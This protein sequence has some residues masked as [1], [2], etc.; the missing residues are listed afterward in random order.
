MEFIEFGGEWYMNYISLAHAIAII[1]HFLTEYFNTRNKLVS[2]FFMVVKIFTYFFTHYAVQTGIVFEECR[3][4]IIDESQVMAWLSYEVIAFYLNIVAIAVFILFSSCKK[5]Y[6]LRDRMQLAG[7]RR[8]KEDFLNYI[9]EDIHWFCMW[10]TMLMLTILALVMRTRSHE[11]I[12]K[13]VGVLFTRHFLELI[14]MGSFYY[15]KDF[16]LGTFFKAVIGCILLINIF[17]I[18]VF[19]ELETEF[20]VWWAPVVLL[21]VTLHFYM[22]FQIGYMY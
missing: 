20:S 14:L 11:L 4:G 22:F 9:K 21:D 18:L 13:S 19:L 10:F 7:E 15:S 16:S 12:Q 1:S 2:G 3:D 17:L 8:K 5:F 6:T